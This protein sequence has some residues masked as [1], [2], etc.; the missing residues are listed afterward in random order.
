MAE[1]DTTIK[2]I[3]RAQPQQWLERLGLPAHPCRWIDTDLSTVAAVTD[4]VIWVDAPNQSWLL[5]LEFMT[6]Y[7]RKLAQRLR[8]DHALL[9]YHY[10]V[11]VTTLAVLLRREANVPALNGQLAQESPGLLGGAFWYQVE[12]LWETPATAL[13]A[14]N[15]LSVTLA[16]LG[17]AQPEQLPTLTQQMRTRLQEEVVDERE[18]QVLWTSAYLLGGM[19]WDKQLLEPLMQQQSLWEASSTCRALIEETKAGVYHK[20]IIRLGTQR[21]GVPQ[22]AQREALIKELNEERLENLHNRL[23]AASSWTELLATNESA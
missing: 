10:E 15:L 1:L 22:P 2:D 7:D 3:L 19:R 12:R 9:Q 5:H 14:G 11:P 6:Y 17:A 8:R 13:V 16:L 20:M 23:L 18:R 4:K 21:F